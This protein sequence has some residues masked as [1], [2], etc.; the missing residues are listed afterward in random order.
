MSKLVQVNSL[1]HKRE[2]VNL[3]KT[4]GKTLEEWAEE[5]NKNAPAHIVYA[6]ETPEEEA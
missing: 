3:P 6:V 5:F 1:T 4:N 2:D